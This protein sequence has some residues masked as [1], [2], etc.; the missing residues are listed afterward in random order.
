[1][2]KMPEID[3]YHRQTLL[4]QIGPAGQLRL[5]QARILLMGCGAL[6]CVIADQ[7][8]RAGVGFLRLV[9]RDWVE[10]TNLQRQPLFDEADAAGQTPKAIA[11]ARRL[12]RVN[13][14]VT[15]DPHVSD[16][17]PSNAAA[18]AGLEGPSGPPVDLI[19]DGT[20]N[21]ETRYLINDLAVKH[22]L[23][24]IYGACVGTEGRV[25]TIKRDS[26]CLR[27]IFPNPPARGELPTC[28]TAGVLGSAAG[29]VASLEVVA[30]LKI[31]LD[32]AA[33]ASLQTLDAWSPRLHVADLAGARD[34]DCPCCGRREFTFL[35][36]RGRGT[37]TSLCGRN[38][39][40]ILPNNGA[41]ATDLT[42]LARRLSGQGHI[43]LTP[44]LL[45]LQLSELPGIQLT[46]F[47]DG[48]LI[49]QGTTDSSRAKTI[50]AKYLGI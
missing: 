21:V 43:A 7:L 6:G 30:A 28:D 10:L 38:A 12:K 50:A 45:R 11:A 23:P 13:S 44:F 26:A 36:A 17:H 40:Q 1:M 42:A 47:T 14:A 4:P 32:P 35:D 49:V 18:L 5:A 24:W 48:R 37:G 34:A 2:R 22:S 9:D 33:P 15:I 29:I 41:T 31:L 16:F 46:I 20:D 3:R 25:M 39:V 8:A 27:C 19:I